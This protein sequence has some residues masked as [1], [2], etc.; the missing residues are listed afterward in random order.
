MSTLHILASFHSWLDIH[1]RLHTSVSRPEYDVIDNPQRQHK[2]RSKLITPAITSPTENSPARSAKA[3]HE[4]RG[5]GALD[6][7]VDDH[8]WTTEQVDSRRLIPGHVDQV[9]VM[10]MSDFA[11]RVLSPTPQSTYG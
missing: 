7:A 2:P 6:Q 1:N 8:K 9:G 11:A 10:C 5:T 4:L 3:A